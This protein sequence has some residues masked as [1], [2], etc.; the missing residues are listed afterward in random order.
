MFAHTRLHIPRGAG[1]TAK[2]SLGQVLGRRVPG[3]VP[4][5]QTQSKRRDGSTGTAR[6]SKVQVTDFSGRNDELGLT[7]WE[8]VPLKVSGEELRK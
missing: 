4:E 5:H 7:G 8:V 1:D 3:R 6:K 2:L